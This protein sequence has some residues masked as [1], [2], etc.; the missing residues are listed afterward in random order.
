VRIFLE[1]FIWNKQKYTFGQGLQ[2]GA[3]YL[4]VENTQYTSANK[5]TLKN[6]SS[7]KKNINFPKLKLFLATL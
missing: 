1:N 3:V 7:A 4:I 5:N 6:T 2:C